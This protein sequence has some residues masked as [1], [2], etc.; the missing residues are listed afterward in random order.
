MVIYLKRFI[1]RI[2][3]FF[4][5]I[6][7]KKDNHCPYCASRKYEVIFKKRGILFLEV[8]MLYSRNKAEHFERLG[9][10]H[11]LGFTK[12][13]F[14]KNL[15]REGF[16]TEVY[17]GYRDLIPDFRKEGDSLVVIGIKHKEN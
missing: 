14:L 15:T 5:A 2:I 13:F 10:V 1:G 12:E 11:Q 7:L 8:P 16:K 9:I 3:Y 17:E 6:F 4:E